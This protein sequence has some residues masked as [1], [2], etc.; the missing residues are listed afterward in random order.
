VRRVGRDRQVEICESSAGETRGERDR[1]R[2]EGG[3][4][5]NRT[6]NSRRIGAVVA[7]VV[8]VDGDV[9][10]VLFEERLVGLSHAF[11]LPPVLGVAGVPVFVSFLRVRRRMKA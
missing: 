11:D 3:G 9:Y 8:A 7:V 5:R 4:G 2:E 1:E 10:A 6:E